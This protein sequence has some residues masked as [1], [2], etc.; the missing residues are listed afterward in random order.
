MLQSSA[1]K[2]DRKSENRN[3][4]PAD[5]IEQ[6][7]FR[8]TRKRIFYLLF[9]TVAKRFAQIHKILHIAAHPTVMTAEIR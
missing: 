5:I 4:F 6:L 7:E 2:K 9:E 1:N 3:A 8:Q